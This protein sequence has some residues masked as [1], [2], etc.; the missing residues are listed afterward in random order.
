MDTT[1]FVFPLKLPLHIGFCVIGTLLFALQ[2][3]RKRQYHQL[4]LAIAIP[5]TLLV[6]TCSTELSYFLLGVEE[7][8]LYII[9][10]VSMIMSNRKAK[11]KMEIEESKALEDSQKAEV[12]EAEAEK[13]PSETVSEKTSGNAE[14]AQ[15]IIKSLDDDKAAKGGAA[16]DLKGKRAHSWQTVTPEQMAPKVQN[17]VQEPAPAPKDDVPAEPSENP[18]WKVIHPENRSASTAWTEVTPHRTKCLEHVVVGKE[19]IAV[20]PNITINFTADTEEDSKTFVKE[21]DHVNAIF[22]DPHPS[23]IQNQESTRSS[24]DNPLLRDLD[25]L[26]SILSKGP[27]SSSSMTAEDILKELGDAA[28]Q[29]AKKE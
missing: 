5:S 26:T 10:L 24:K 16:P 7:V 23:E 28:D 20:G 21:I 2:Y 18:N 6:Y 17:P 25:I 9:I 11:K 19:H 14:N 22:S 3:Y 13:K 29:R 8:V 1:S 12:K 27:N 15:S 4:L